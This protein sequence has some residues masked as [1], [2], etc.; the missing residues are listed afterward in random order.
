MTATE[1][2]HALGRMQGEL[3]TSAN[4]VTQQAERLRCGNQEGSEFLADGRALAYFLRDAIRIADACKP[5]VDAAT[6]IAIDAAL[7]RVGRACPDAINARDALEHCDDYVLGI[8]NQ[9][10]ARPGEYGQL[11]DRGG[12]ALRVRVGPLVVDVAMAELAANHLANV[13]L[14]GTDHLKLL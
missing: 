11:Y 2:Q 8:G 9:Q 1:R 7:S 3:Y 12:S 10:E 13:V 4:G 14:A 5:L 6:A